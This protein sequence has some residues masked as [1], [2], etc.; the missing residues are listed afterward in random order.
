MRIGGHHTINCT[1][2]TNPIPHDLLEKLVNEADLAAVHNVREGR[3]GPFGASLNVIDLTNNWVIRI[4]EVAG[5]AVLETG[6]GSA[7]AEDQALSPENI[8]ALKAQLKNRDSAKTAVIVASS[9]ESCPACHAKLEILARILIDEGLLL[10]GHFIV[11]YGASYADTLAVAGFNDEPYH[12]DMLKPEGQRLIS[13]TSQNF[14]ALPPAIQDALSKGGAALQ[15]GEEI[16]DGKDQRT[17]HFTWTP[18]VIALKQACHAR[19]ARHDPTP[20]DLH[21]ASL[22]TVSPTI[23]PLAYAEAQWAN[24]AHWIKV[25]G[26]PQQIATEAPAI[27]NDDLFK[28]IAKRPYN[29]ADSCL[30]VIK[31]DHFANQGQQEWARIQ[32]EQPQKLKIY[33][34]IAS[35]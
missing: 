2:M 33:N 17:T 14:D 8:R 27:T 26:S 19:K 18:E 10:R 5:N 15:S 34:G 35:S 30:C 29:H 20:W 31:V 28:A 21:Q 24:V 12:A 13:V 9:A 3:G 4:G 32:T 23:G 6:M 7:H 11:A 16:F 22:Y 25:T 1:S